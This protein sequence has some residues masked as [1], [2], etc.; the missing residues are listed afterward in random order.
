MEAN[1][2]R[3]KVIDFLMNL[4]N[5]GTL[6]GVYGR[7]VSLLLLYKN[8]PQTKNPGFFPCVFQ[9]RVIRPLL[10]RNKKAISSLQGSKCKIRGQ[11]A[12]FKGSRKILLYYDFIPR[13]WPDKSDGLCHTV[14]SKNQLNLICCLFL[15]LEWWLHL[16]KLVALQVKVFCVCQKISVKKKDVCDLASEWVWLI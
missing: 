5:S 13:E 3:G 14:T 8:F 10:N 15:F 11:N 2:S 4:K 9:I 12:Q 1:K 6:P 7:L 16:L